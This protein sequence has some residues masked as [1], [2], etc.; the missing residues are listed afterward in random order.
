MLR[1][2]IK[3]I[4]RNLLRHKA[5]SFLNIFGLAIGMACSIMILLWVQDE[6]NY[7]RFH[8]HADQLYRITCTTTDIKG[9][10]IPAPVAAALKA[11][12][13]EVKNTV[14]LS[15][16]NNLFQVGNRRFEENRVFYADASF[17]EL[18][19][20]R[21]SEGNPETALSRPDGILIT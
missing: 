12:F 7:D 17:L 21:L 14:R 15:A 10:T 9:A 16:S 4:F 13:P 20:F 19:S 2:Y 8:V 18:F 5:F 6:I 1:N 3:I 11:E